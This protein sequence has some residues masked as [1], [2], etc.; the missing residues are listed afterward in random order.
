MYKRWTF[1]KSAI[2]SGI[3]SCMIMSPWSV[4]RTRLREIIIPMEIPPAG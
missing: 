2:Y 1:F 4:F 3:A